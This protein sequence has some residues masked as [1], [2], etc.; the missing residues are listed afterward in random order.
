MSSIFEVTVYNK[1]TTEVVSSG[2]TQLPDTLETE[3]LGV[4]VGQLCIPRE[5]YVCRNVLCKYTQSEILSRDNLQLGWVWKMPER[6][7]VDNRA[8]E[9][10]KIIAY[11]KINNYRD[12]LISSFDRFTYI[13]VVYDGNA[14][15]QENIRVAAFIANSNSPLPEGFSWRSFDNVDVPM[16]K[17]KVLGLQS[18]LLQSLATITFNSH[19]TARDLKNKIELA[20]TN[21]QVDAITWPTK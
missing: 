11:D 21:E 17:E 16:N 9:Q 10:A 5:S 20:T 1:I 15:A 13:S 12:L 19:K 18:A 8:L 4:L 2:T 6:I 3:T 14:A 7:S